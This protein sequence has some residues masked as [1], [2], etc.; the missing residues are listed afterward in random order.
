M[1]GKVGGRESTKDWGESEKGRRGEKNFKSHKKAFL[2]VFASPFLRFPVSF[3]LFFFLFF[4]SLL[5]GISLAAPDSPSF[6]SALPGWKFEFPRDHRAHK[7]FRT[8]W[9]YYNGHLTGPAGERFGYQLTFFRVGLIP[10]SLP[11]KGSRWEL[12]EVYLAH[13]AVTE[14]EGRIFQFKEKISRGSL[15]L[16][17]AEG[18]RYRVWLESWQVDE[19]GTNHR[20]QAGDRDLALAL[21]LIPVRPPLVHGLDG[22]SQK[23]PKPGQASH[24]YSLT[25]MKTEGYLTRKG[26][27]IPV[28]GL[29]WMDHEFGSNQ[30]AENQVGWDWF[31]I[32]LNDGTDLMLYQL[33]Q[34]QGQVDPRSSGT[35]MLAGGKSRHLPVERI[36]IR[37]L[38]SWKSPRTGAVYPAAWEILLPENDLKLELT[39]L[40]N[41]QE[42]VTSKSTGVTYWEGAV[43]VKGIHRGRS[44]E[45]KGYVEMTGY[46]RP[47]QPKI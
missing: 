30:L 37:T 6:K 21:T 44:V 36:K 40:I 19:E 25:R 7:D 22:V 46:D 42:L 35:L 13:L 2:R 43:E 31:S 45:G 9:W 28:Q 4:L 14:V 5:A 17:G 41:D 8:E 38:K 1:S 32:Q 15:G 26:K 47:F 34:V 33:R 16:A 27:R 39:P 18:R 11:L 20:L 29:S 10:G 3:S 23:G 12:R 24:Y